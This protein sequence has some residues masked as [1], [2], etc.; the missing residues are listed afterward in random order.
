MSTKY[1]PGAWISVNMLADSAIP[2][3]RLYGRFQG[4]S[5]G[6]VTMV[7]I[8][9]TPAARTGLG[10]SGHRGHRE[11]GRGDEIAPA[12]FKNF[13]RLGSSIAFLVVRRVGL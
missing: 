1:W 12:R 6:R 4:I 3:G 5:F 2:G 10:R 13:D 11:H 9:S 7:V 8:G